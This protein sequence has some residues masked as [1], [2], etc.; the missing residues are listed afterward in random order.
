M[1]SKDYPNVLQNWRGWEMEGPLPATAGAHL[2]LCVANQL[3][4]GPSSQ[5]EF[6]SQVPIGGVRDRSM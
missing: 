5:A 1:L 2:L 6:R 3:L 4:L